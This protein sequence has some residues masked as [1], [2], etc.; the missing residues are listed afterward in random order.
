MLKKS[1]KLRHRRK[2]LFQFCF[3]FLKIL[4]LEINDIKNIQR[5]ST[6]LSES[7]LKFGFGLILLECE[8]ILG[9]TFRNHFLRN[10]HEKKWSFPNSSRI[11]GSFP[12][13]QGI[14]QPSKIFKSCIGKA[15]G[16]PEKIW[17]FIRK[18]RSEQLF[19]RI[20]LNFHAGA[21]IVPA[22]GLEGLSFIENMNVDVSSLFK[23]SLLE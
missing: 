14:K 23:K 8:N 9:Q 6:K 5:K 1:I 15:L 3:D 13:L 18:R 16:P 19:G 10:L 2:I 21:C 12:E 4:S 11:P 17:K 20:L 22:G 7:T